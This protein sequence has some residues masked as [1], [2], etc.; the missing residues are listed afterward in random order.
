MNGKMG[1]KINKRR[2]FLCQW[3]GPKT[4]FRILFAHCDGMLQKLE[5]ITG[6]LSG[7]NEF[8]NEQEEILKREIQNIQQEKSLLNCSF[9][10][11]L[12]N[13]L[14]LNGFHK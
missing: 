10:H 14:F 12:A 4:I 9:L 8:L 13:Y 1:K 11:V 2:K 3:T 5:N 6:N 7:R